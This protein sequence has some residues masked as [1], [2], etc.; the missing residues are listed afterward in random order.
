MA[1]YPAKTR[2]GAL[3]RFVAEAG[4]RLRVDVTPHHFYSDVP[5]FKALRRDTDWR[6]PMSMTGIAG[7]DIA[8]QVA[9]MR[10]C[11]PGFPELATGSVYEQAIARNGEAGYGPIEARFLY[12]FIR[13]KRPRRI[14][15]IGCG[16]STAI[17][18]HAA[19]DAGYTPELTCIEPYPTGLLR[20]ESQAGR[21]RLVPQPAQSVPMETLTGLDAGDLL[22]VDST[23]TV[24]V[25]SEVV[26]I[27]LEVLPRLRP[28]VIVHFHDIMF[29]YDYAPGILGQDVFLWRE[30][31]LLLA[32][33]T[34]NPAYR[35]LAS[36]S[37]VHHADPGAMK[38]LFPDYTP[39]VME[40]AV[41][42]APGHFPSATYLER[43]KGA[44]A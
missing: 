43:L 10:S 15:Q 13:S 31:T 18:L 44:G 12:A 32:F 42:K 38:S 26:R 41:V 1:L 8:G 6:H 33:L 20:E 5:D 34:M 17:I 11:C 39:M 23:H 28:G 24:K 35:I 2:K 37:M 7:T 16:V 36:L 30:T 40:D 9:F 29:P 14:V 3:L 4:Q 22:F 21:I 27:I 19:R 25:G